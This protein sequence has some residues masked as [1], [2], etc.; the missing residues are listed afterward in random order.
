M[1]GESPLATEDAKEIAHVRVT[2]DD[3]F[4]LHPLRAHL[5]E[6]AARAAA[7]ARP[8]QGQD[9]AHCAG[10]PAAEELII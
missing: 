10:M 9:W 8:F 7:F 3:D 6:T 2:E 4:R 1:S 5:R